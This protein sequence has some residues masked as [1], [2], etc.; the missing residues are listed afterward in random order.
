MVRSPLHRARPPR[1]PASGTVLAALGGVAAF[2]LATAEPAAAALGDPLEPPPPNVVMI[3]TDD[4]PAS[5]VTLE[6]MPNVHDLLIANGTSFSDYVVTTPLCCPSR[7]TAITGQY[8]HNN[9]VLSND[10]ALLR[11]SNVLPAWLRS[12]GYTTAHVGKYL[13]G[14]G[15]YTGSQKEVAP[16]WDLWFT[17][18]ERKSYYNWNA[19]KNG[20]FIGYGEE[21]AD[22]LTEVTN[23]RAVK[24]TRKLVKEPEPFYLQ[25]DYY[26][27]HGASGRDD[28]CRLGPV[29]APRDEG[30]FGAATLPEP[31][32]F[33]EEDVSD[34]PG[35]IQSRP[36]ID[37]ETKDRIGR[38][39]RC[40]LES[41]RAV[42]RGI[43]KVYKRIERSG[44]L[45]RTIFIFTSDNGYF[46]GEHRVERGKPFPYEENL[47]MPLTIVVPPPYRG[48]GELV[49]EAG[50][51]AANID[52]APTILDLA[53]AE[54][55]RVPARCRTMDGRSLLPL[56]AGKGKGKA[57]PADRELLIEFGDCGYRGLRT[58]RQIYFEYSA[59][60]PETSQCVRTEVEHYDLDDDPFQL[61]NLYPA[62]D[63]SPDSDL[64]AELTQRVAGLRFCAGIVGRDLAPDSGVYCG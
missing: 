7:A 13:N 45:D 52:L 49:P 46:F 21:D 53:G 44:E 28:R 9:G 1:L 25:L 47:R 57:W 58:D 10:Y 51:P 36:L 23:A 40:T 59:P 20:K 63:P 43:G 15:D 29:P 34:K 37:A 5:T 31:P 12:A 38:R 39:Y 61:E 18:F 33:N 48:D 11:K 62:P 41:L 32:S 24:W 55:C 4:Q 50:Q 6:A 30:V 19:S 22:H 2:A 3:T 54:P 56:L 64:Q 8:G 26:A 60:S 42:D 14:F 27:P 17:Q 16:G 35:F